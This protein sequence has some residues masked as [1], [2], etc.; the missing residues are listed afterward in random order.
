MR[1]SM[2]L[3]KRNGWYYIRF[4][5]T[6]KRALRTKDKRVAQRLFKA[7]ERE[8][9]KGRLI[10]LDEGEKIT[11]AEF[12]DIFFKRH[13]DIA[14]R[15]FDAYELAAD[16]LI[17]S[18]GGSTLLKRINDNKIEKFKSDCLTRKVK[19]VSINTYLRH[20]RGFLNK[21]HEWGYTNEKAKIKFYKL[22]KRLPTIFT[23]KEIKAIR[24]YAKKHDYQIYRFLEFGLWS[25]CRRAEIANF[26]WQHLIDENSTRIYGKG[27]KERV[28]PLL[29]G[30]KKAM[31][32]LKILAMCLSIITI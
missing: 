27:N 1:I 2:K 20:I 21:A 16:L 15:T 29:P 7:V 6:K 11:L 25:A 23:P 10:Q 12:K 14:D 32:Q 17:D 8:I 9:L 5:R 13:T 24:K 19:K 31:G 30:A 18:I 4:S 26:Q 28:I 3:F 22:S